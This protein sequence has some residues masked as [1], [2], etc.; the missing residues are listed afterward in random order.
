MSHKRA[1][2]ASDLSESQWDY[3]KP[4]IPLEHEGA[5]RPIELDMREVVNAMLYVARSECQWGNL[6]HDFPN[7]N[8]VYYHFRKWCVVTD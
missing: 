1:K 5:G 3:I 2:Y 4:L 7:V 8:S 6:P